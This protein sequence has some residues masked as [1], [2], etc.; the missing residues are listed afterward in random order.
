M[1]SR[2][3]ENQQ[4][5]RQKYPDFVTYGQTEF[6]R[7]SYP[8]KVPSQTNT[9]HDKPF[10]DKHQTRQTLDITNASFVLFLSSQGLSCLVF[11]GLWSVMEPLQNLTHRDSEVP[12]LQSRL[13][14]YYLYLLCTP[15]I[16]TI[17]G[18]IEISRT[19]TFNKGS[20]DHYLK[21]PVIQKQ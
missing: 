19:D 20:E 17:F 18:I 5:Y 2:G 3:S 16:F 21:Y 15:G 11:V 14:N 1:Q 13:A 10:T 6:Q 4:I 9:R 8:K 12:C 7:I